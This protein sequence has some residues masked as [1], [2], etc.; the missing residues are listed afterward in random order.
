MKARV[1]VLALALAFCVFAVRA[2]E[3]SE[4]VDAPQVDAEGWSSI[5]ILV[6]SSCTI[7]LPVAHMRC[8]AYHRFVLEK[9]IPERTL[10]ELH[11]VKDSFLRVS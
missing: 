4:P 6:C 5:A 3:S 10:Q 2:E 11:M 9:R 1:C 8:N 7:D